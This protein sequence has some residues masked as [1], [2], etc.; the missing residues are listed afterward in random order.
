M[1]E[2]FK[3]WRRKVGVRDAGD[4]VRVGGGMGAESVES[5]IFL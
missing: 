1:R 4:G 3:G 5:P 2:F